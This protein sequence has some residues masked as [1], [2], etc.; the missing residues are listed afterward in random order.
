VRYCKQFGPRSVQKEFPGEVCPIPISEDCL[1]LNVFTPVWSPEDKK[2]FATIVYVHGGGFLFDS[3]W[4]YGDIN[5]CENLVTKDVVVVTVQ[6]RCGYLGMFSTGDSVCPG[7]NLLWDL[8]LALQW[9]KDNISF[10]N[11]D[12]NNV[13]VIGQ[14]A[15][16]ALAHYLSLSPHSRDLFH[17]VVPMAGDTCD[18]WS[19]ANRLVEVCQEKATAL[20]VTTNDSAQMVEELRKVPAE[21]FALGILDSAD[22]TKDIS[23]DKTGLAPIFDGDF[24]PKPID[25]LRK[26]APQK[27]MLTG[28]CR[29][30]G[31]IYLPDCTQTRKTIEGVAAAR[32]AEKHYPKQY[33]ELREEYVKRLTEDVRNEETLQR[34]IAQAMGDHMFIIGCQQNVIS[35]LENGHPGVYLYVMDYFNEKMNGIVTANSPFQGATHCCDVSFL[36]QKNIF[37]PFEF[38]GED[39]KV[40]NTIATYFTNFAKFGNP[41]GEDETLTEWLPATKENPERNLQIDRPFVMSDSYFS[42][43]PRWV[44]EKTKESE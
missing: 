31:L 10:F 11:G 36:I 44:V 21:S 4:K 12:P 35:H 39:K 33:R 34:A 17:K 7:N 8:T 15:G 23:M 22:E 41:N 19:L 40:S 26:E 37:V 25:E 29:Y 13:T 18:F 1:N 14:S 2:G 5:I 28:V 43:R 38:E 16:G 32:F 24:F 30:E 27:P 20:G 42:G 6:Y 9:V 3:A